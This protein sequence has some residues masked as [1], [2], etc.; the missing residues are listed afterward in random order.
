MKTSTS[1]VLF[2]LM[3]IVALI[4]FIFFSPAAAGG[5]V[6]CTL[7]GGA[8]VTTDDVRAN[9]STLDMEDISTQVTEILP[10]RVPLNKI[11]R[12]IRKA[13]KVQSQILRYYSVASKDLYDVTDT[14]A[15][16]AGTSSGAPAKAYTYSS[17]DGLTSIYL[18][19][20][21]ADLWEVDGTAHI[22]EHACNATVAASPTGKKDI[23]FWVKSKTDNVVN[24]VPQNGC[25][26]SGSNAAVY[27]VPNIA[28][29]TKFYLAGNAM[30]ETAM[31][32][33]PF[34]ILPTPLEQYCQNFMAQVE[35][36]VFQE[37]TKKEVQFGFKDYEKQNIYNMAIKQELSF[38]Y[39]IKAYL[40]NAS[41][42]NYRYTTEGITRQ[43]DTVLTYGTGSG[44][45]TV[46]QDNYLTWMKTVFTGNNGSTDRVLFAGAGLMKSLHSIDEYTKQ[47]NGTSTQI[48]WGL[49]F[50][51]IV[52][53]FGNLLVYQHPL[54]S[55]IGRDDYGLILDMA[56][57]SKHDFIPMSIKELDLVTSGQ[58]N[59]KAKVLQEVSAL[60]LQNPDCHAII[61]PAA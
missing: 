27:V 29:S 49:T 58:R 7:V 6:F 19:V 16:G 10:A 53:D 33:V 59:V 43:I 5:V 22:Y 8:A 18:Q 14:N 42:A 47:L 12:E 4:A 1:K 26:G 13:N 17:G 44:N 48:Q 15:S 40:N 38:L 3:S 24:L 25:L 36:S 56:H 23:Q 61:K 31:Q 45:T 50:N 21:N 32:A 46:S 9:V 51:K 35:E 60:T 11:M 57:I 39:G 55:Q 52:S 30:P 34:G 37:M 28:T 54:F 2:G 41:S 20:T